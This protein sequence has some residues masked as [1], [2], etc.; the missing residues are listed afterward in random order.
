MHSE[1]DE[2][3]T[4]RA[5][6]RPT[7]VVIEEDDEN[8]EEERYSLT[9]TVAGFRFP[10]KSPEMVEQLEN[11]VRKDSTLRKQ[12][13]GRSNYIFKSSTTFVLLIYPFRLHYFASSVNFP[14]DLLSPSWSCST[15]RHCSITTTADGATFPDR[16]KR[17]WRITA[18]LWNASM[19]NTTDCLWIQSKTYQDNCF[20]FSEAWGGQQTAEEL[21]QNICSAITLINNRKRGARFRSKQRNSSQRKKWP[22]GCRL[23]KSDLPFHSER[24]CSLICI[25]V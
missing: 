12:Y 3:Y 18:S 16:R 25:W 2:Q 6:R 10:L 15:T 24:L 19:V 8:T 22:S 11:A 9:Q 21:R 1:S 17:P 5:V 20:H 7:E 14:Y 23:D 13:V 4:I